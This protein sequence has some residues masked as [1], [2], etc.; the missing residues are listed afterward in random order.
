MSASKRSSSAQIRELISKRFAQPAPGSADIDSSL[1]TIIRLNVKSDVRPYERNP[2]QSPNDK[3]SEIKDSIRTRGLDHMIVVTRRPDQKHYIPAKGGNTRVQI[4]HELV[5]EGVKELEYIDFYEIPYPGEVA[6]MAAHWVENE[7]RAALNFWD[8]ARS[9]YELKTEVEKEQG[10]ELSQREYSEYLK[11]IQ[12]IQASQ[13]L[14]SHYGF[15]VRE[16]NG[17]G[18]AGSLLTREDVRER[19]IPTRA[20]MA[21]LTVRLEQEELAR[22]AWDLAIGWARTQFEQTHGLDVGGLLEQFTEQVAQGLNVPLDGLK[23]MQQVLAVD[24]AATAHDLR[25]ALAQPDAT[26]SPPAGESSAPE[27]FAKIQPGTK[28]VR[29]TGDP[30]STGASGSAGV[31][32]SP[33]ARPPVES[34]PTIHGADAS[35]S[36]SSDGVAP[37]VDPGNAPPPVSHDPNGALWH[38]LRAFCDACELPGSLVETDRLPFGF[39]AEIPADLTE[40]GPSLQESALA[41]QNRE[42]YHGWWMLVAL[43]CQNIPAGLSILPPETRYAHYASSNALWELGCEKLLGEDP[44]ESVYAHAFLMMENPAEPIGDAYLALL[45]ATREFRRSHPQRFTSKFW[46]SQGVQAHLVPYAEEEDGA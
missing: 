10:K 45:H 39:M 7:Q 24:A 42:R 36:A 15:V 20:A 30:V 6:L 28:N 40:D 17:L 41:G 34:S 35:A 22:G 43:S 46:L 9:I 1:A 19:I 4:L 11:R 8:S 16:L 14:L 3:Y 27:Q 37:A 29:S 32:A 18:S 26:P 2:R 23:R 13:S 25:A 44:Y 33:K 38:A 31:A 5:D 21:T 12:G